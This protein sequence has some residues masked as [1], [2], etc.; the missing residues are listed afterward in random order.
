MILRKSLLLNFGQVSANL[1][2]IVPCPLINVGIDVLQILEDTF[3]QRT[4]PCANFVDDEVFIGEVLKQ[5]FRHKAFCDSLTIIWLCLR[6]DSHTTANTVDTHLEE[7][8]R[9]MP[10]LFSGPVMFVCAVCNIPLRYF[11]LKLC[12]I[13]QVVKVK[14]RSLGVKN[15]G[16]SRKVPIVWI[17]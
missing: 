7:F 4:V 1:N 10:Q 15:D 3:R 13:S 12:R 14:W 6:W 9:S 2:N 17:I 5:V 8:G 11:L 16:L